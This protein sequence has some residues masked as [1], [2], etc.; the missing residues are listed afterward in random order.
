MGS[1]YPSEAF[2]L[3]FQLKYSLVL[4]HAFESFITL[5]THYNLLSVCSGH[6]EQIQSEDLENNSH[7]IKLPLRNFRDENHIES[8]SAVTHGHHVLDLPNKQYQVCIHQRTQPNDQRHSISYVHQG[9][10]NIIDTIDHQP[11]EEVVLDIE[12]TSNSIH[13]VYDVN[14]NDPATLKLNVCQNGLEKNKHFAL[15][16]GQTVELDGNGNND[17]HINHLHN[18]DNSMTMVSTACTR[19]PTDT[20]NNSDYNK[21]AVHTRDNATK[22]LPMTCRT[23]SL[24]K[25]YLEQ[26][27]AVTLDQGRSSN[28]PSHVLSES[29]AFMQ[30]TSPMEIPRTGERF[31]RSS[32]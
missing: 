2:H 26:Q 16:N 31:H 6:G 12:R 21:V 18:G 9:G 15:V 25:T 24:T 14:V 5:I 8:K 10:R 27:E 17:N 20:D 11:V 22:A 1:N 3:V 23:R 19:I 13:A 32:I 4:H 28:Q 7:C 30:N 29:V